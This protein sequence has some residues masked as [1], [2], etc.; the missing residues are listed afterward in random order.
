MSRANRID[1]Q[2][3][4]EYDNSR[5]D[6]SELRSRVIENEVDTFRMER[7]RASTISRANNDQKKSLSESFKLINVL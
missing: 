1:E 7:V 3:D 6:M 2:R 4:I 5:I